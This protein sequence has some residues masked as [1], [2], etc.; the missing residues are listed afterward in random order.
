[1][2][3]RST[4]KSQRGIGVTRQDINVS[5]RDGARVEIKGVQDLDMIGQLIDK[6]IERQQSLLANGEKPKEETRIAKEDGSTEF[7]RPLPGGERMYPETDLGTFIVNEKYLAS[8]KIPETWESM[9]SQMIKSEYLDLYE[10]FSKEVEPVLVAN[11]FTSILKDLRRKGLD[12]SSIRE[13]TFD[14]LFSSVKSKNISKEAIP[15]VMEI[16]CKENISVADAIGKSGLRAM[17]E[18]QLRSIVKSVFAKYP[19]LAKEKKF[20]PLMGEVM[21]EVRGKIGGDV[22]SKV[23][24]EELKNYK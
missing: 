22:V 17:S 5:I 16:V 18:E 21:K 15:N 2:I 12:V 8:I 6:E 7:T 9:V 13:E 24:N 14:D 19:Q 1:M 4:G 3:I 10:K 11:T 20:S 23:L